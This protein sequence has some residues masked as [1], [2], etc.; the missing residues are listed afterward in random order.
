ML[1]Q[2]KNSHY[3]TDLDHLINY[4][5]VTPKIDVEYLVIG[6]ENTKKNGFS[7]NIS[8]PKEER[9]IEKEISKKVNELQLLLGM[10][11]GEHQ[12]KRGD[13]IPMEDVWKKFKDKYKFKL[14]DNDKRNINKKIKDDKN[15][16]EFIFDLIENRDDIFK[17]NIKKP[18]MYPSPY[19]NHL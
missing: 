19:P 5:K 8:R 9:K 3:W 15:L 14:S 13:T 17:K 12:I 2:I 4:L 16:S 11:I 7:L 10:Y 1:Q 18:K 6:L